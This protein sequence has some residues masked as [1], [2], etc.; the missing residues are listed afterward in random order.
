MYK[1]LLTFLLIAFA[2]ASFAQDFEAEIKR[3]SKNTT[4]IPYGKNKAAGK[5]YPIRGFNMYAETYGQGRPLLFIHGNGGSIDNFVNQ[6][7]YFSKKYK[8]IVADSRAQGK[9]KDPGD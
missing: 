1:Y 2:Y 7:P 4:G 8:V 5:F 3:L 9:S 6:I